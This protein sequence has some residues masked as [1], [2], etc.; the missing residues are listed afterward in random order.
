MKELSHL[1][2]AQKYLLKTHT[3]SVHD[4]IKQFKCNICDYKASRKDV[5]LKHVKSVHEGIKYKTCD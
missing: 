4:G 3:E 5:F 2:E 1:N